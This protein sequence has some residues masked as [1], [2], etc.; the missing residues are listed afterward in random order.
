MWE[1]ILAPFGSWRV[2]RRVE[3]AQLIEVGW[4]ESRVLFSSYTLSIAATFTPSDGNRPEGNVVVDAYGNL[5][6]LTQRGANTNDPTI[7]GLPRGGNSIST[8]ASLPAG[9]TTAGL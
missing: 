9:E 8:L 6:G 2:G 1:W 7:F 5:F 3:R 4:L